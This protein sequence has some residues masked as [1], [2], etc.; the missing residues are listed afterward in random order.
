M[1]S[2]LTGEG[3]T[4]GWDRVRRRKIR[5]GEGVV[6]C[7]AWGFTSP[8]SLPS[9]PSPCGQT[10]A[11]MRAVTKF[12]QKMIQISFSALFTVWICISLS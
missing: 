8:P 9:K 1:T 6:P 11:W 12:N 2:V 4:I 10:H 5:E 7:P 3:G